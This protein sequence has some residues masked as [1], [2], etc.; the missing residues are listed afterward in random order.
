[1][2]RLES[3]LK[4][5]GFLA[6][7]RHLQNVFKT[8]SGRLAKAFSRHLQDVFKTSLR[9]LL[10]MYE[11]REYVR[12]DEDVLKTKMKDILKTSSRRLHQDECLLGRPYQTVK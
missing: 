5:F 9:R 2:I 8:S 11:Y 3:A 12:L 4:A 6:S 1:M 7:S 10:K